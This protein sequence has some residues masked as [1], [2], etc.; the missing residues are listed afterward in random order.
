MEK[1]CSN[2]FILKISKIIKFCLVCFKF[3]KHIFEASVAFPIYAFFAILPISISSI[4]GA[5]IFQTMG[6]ILKVN[7]IAKQNLIKCFPLMTE[8]E[9]N[10]TV[11]LMWQN[12]GAIVGEMPHWHR[13]SDQELRS[14]INLPDI[15]P[16][17]QMLMIS[18][19]FGNWELVNRIMKYYKI[20]P[21]FVYRPMNNPMINWLINR[22]RL[23]NN[24]NL[25][26]KGIMSLKE[27]INGIKDGKTIGMLVDQRHDQ[28]ISV[29]FF[30]HE[31]MT[32]SAPASIAIKYHI[33]I[34]IL[35]VKR[36]SMIK[37]SSNFLLSN[38]TEPK[39]EIIIQNIKVENEDSPKVV[40]KK[41]H[42]VLETIISNDKSQWFWL[43]NRWKQIDK[44]MKS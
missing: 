44:K 20:K 6:S 39:F 32:V 33:P 17:E 21:I 15:F 40:M 31:A 43:H 4:I 2:T 42:E 22:T 1:N 9:V 8:N 16:T 30:K 38:F 24:V 7:K 41:I 35:M 25:I 29:P 3:F 5:K 11:K 28:G 26:E 36:L 37:K 18:A 27:L 23:L 13:I 12:L 10:N 19:H 14:F 34:V